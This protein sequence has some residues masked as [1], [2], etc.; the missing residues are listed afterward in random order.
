MPA[1]AFEPSFVAV[2]P[3]S[4]LREEM[5]A[6]AGAAAGG[7]ASDI[8]RAAI[9]EIELLISDGKSHLQRD[10]ITRALDAF[11]KA[12]AAIYRLLHPEFDISHYLSS[13]RVALPISA[14]IETALVTAAGRVVEA[15]RPRSLE[16]TGAFWAASTGT[17]PDNLTAFTRLGLREANPVDQSLQLANERAVALLGSGRPEAALALLDSAPMTGGQTRQNPCL[18]ATFL[19]RAG[20]LLQMGNASASVEAARAAEAAFATVEDK[21]GIAQAIHLSAVALKVM[22]KAEADEA[23]SRAAE[24]ASTLQPRAGIDSQGP[25]AS[26]ALPLT[27]AS[28]TLSFTADSAAPVQALSPRLSDRVT[29]DPTALAPIIR[30]DSQTLTFRIPGRVDGWGSLPLTDN[31]Q[32]AE[33][34]K[35]WSLGVTAGTNTAIFTVSNLEVVAADH[36]VAGLYNPRRAAVSAADLAWSLSDEFATTLYL[37]HLYSYALPLMIADGYHAQQLFSKAE[38]YYLLAAQYSFINPAIEGT[39]LWVRLARNAVD[40]GDALYKGEDL[41]G[42]RT[43]YEKIVTAAAGVPAS[44]LYIVPGL[45]VAAGVATAFIGVINVRP[46]ALDDW[47]IDAVILDAFRELQQIAQGLDYYGLL[48]APIHTF[49]YLQSIAQGFAR[50]AIEAENEF[51][52]FKQRQA[53]E[54]ATRR[55]LQ[56]AKAA[57][58]AEAEGRHQ[59]Y[60]AAQQDEQAAIDA[61]NLADQ[62]A[63]DAG[64]ELGKYRNTSTDEIWSRAASQALA[65]GQDFSRSDIGEIAARLDRGETVEGPGAKLAAAEVLRAG[66]KTQEYELKKMQDNVDELQKARLLAADQLAASKTRTLAADLAWQSAQKR[67]E[68]AAAGLTAFDSQLFTPDSWSKMAATMQDIAQGYLFHA[69]RLAK[70]MERAYNF[71]NDVALKIIRNEYGVAATNPNASGFGTVLGGQLLLQD[72]ESFIYTAVTTRT[73][74]SCRIKDVISVASFYPAQFDAFRQTGRLTFETDLYEFD[75]LHPGFFAQKIHAVELEVVGLLPASG[76][77]GS[78][79]AGGV[80]SFRRRDRTEGKRVQ[81]IDTMALSQYSARGDAFLY[82]AETG[83]KGLFQGFG[84]GTTWQLHTPRRSNDLDFKRIFDIRLILYYTAEYDPVLEASVLAAPVRPGEHAQIRDFALR[85]DFPDAWYGFYANGAVSVNLE[86]IRL[87]INQTNFLTRAV[88]VRV[89][90]KDGFSAAAITVRIVEPGGASGIANTDANGVVTT[91]NPALVGLVGVAPVGI[92]QIQVTGGALLMEGGALQF[93]RVYDI[94]FGIEYSF[95]FVPEV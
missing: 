62:R 67:V 56:M 40:W 14:E 84:I 60:L 51:I 72:I 24:I 52:T 68:L 41:A 28:N 9:A 49:E 18:A 95:D 33:T 15:I 85:Y 74:K 26:A 76:L 48:L 66:R 2:L 8:A 19:T 53:A 44:P 6:A 57:A 16:P 64:N 43:Q 55:E 59:A 29:R 27:I 13:V 17:V 34:S 92:W 50:E 23:F 81:I 90:T 21:A 37:N 83:I 25:V 93:K 63:T 45:A 73:R 61:Q 30:R 65:G 89:V 47:E 54:E 69:I 36:V 78:F 82:T 11:E 86:R 79:T 75:R 7:N 80:T 20:A 46:I 35:P 91:S 1:R 88:N 3:S 10:E 12:R 31:F 5:V 77:N 94:Q 70:L 58:D 87:P 32:R 38:E 22:G 4:R 39:L 42:A 71:E